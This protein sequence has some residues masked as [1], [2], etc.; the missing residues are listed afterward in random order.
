M[1]GH[2][3]LDRCDENVFGLSAARAIAVVTSSIFTVSTCVTV[4]FGNPNA[5]RATGNPC[6]PGDITCVGV[7]VVSDG[8]GATIGAVNDSRRS[9]TGPVRP[10]SACD[11]YATAYKQLCQGNKGAQCLDLYDQFRGD[12][13]TGDFNT[14]VAANSCP[15]VAAGAA[16]APPAPAELARRAAASFHLPLPTGER[17]PSASK[18][19]NG[20]PFTYVGL[21]TY[22]W[23][24][25]MDWRPRT[26]TAAAGGNYATVT[27]T[28]TALIFRLGDGSPEQRCDGPGRAW[29][30]SDGDA[31]PSGDACGVRYSRVTGPGYDRPVTSTQSIRWR[32]TWRGSGNTTGTLT[33]RT[34]ST[35]G[36]LN[37]LQ[38]QTVNR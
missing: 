35:S 12:M 19:V 24:N 20:L 5:A 29:R 7:G 11:R 26:A 23:T 34:T 33:A 22:Y 30:E 2:P 14:F 10:P 17:S 9:P 27:A 15:G 38:I 25:A 1:G 21:W 16:P 18:T 28:P 31:A 32:L 37:V 6:T 3:V 8:H 4:L 36:Q 13:A